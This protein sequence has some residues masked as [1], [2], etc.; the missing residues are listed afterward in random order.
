M[1]SVSVSKCDSDKKNEDPEDVTPL[2]YALQFKWGDFNWMVRRF[3]NQSI[4]CYLMIHFLSFIY[5]F[6]FYEQ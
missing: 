2:S 6:Y 1:L 5:H 3:L 4:S